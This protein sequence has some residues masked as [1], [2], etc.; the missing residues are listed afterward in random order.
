MSLEKSGEVCGISLDLPVLHLA[1]LAFAPSD[2]VPEVRA[3]A[4]V[5]LDSPGGAGAGRE[6]IEG[7]LKARGDWERVVE[8]F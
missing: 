4:H 7:I 3:A 8:G 2:A 1:A 6:M 5:V